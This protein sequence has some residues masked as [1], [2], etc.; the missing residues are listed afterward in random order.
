MVGFSLLCESELPWNGRLGVGALA[1]GCRVKGTG[2]LWNDGKILVL[3]SG[4]GYTTDKCVKCHA[5]HQMQVQSAAN[6]C[7]PEHEQRLG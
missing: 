6:P 1:E 2:E 7:E 3:G 4:G 5:V